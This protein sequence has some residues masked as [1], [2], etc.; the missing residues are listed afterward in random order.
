MYVRDEFAG[1]GGGGV[2]GRL[3]DYDWGCWRE[4]FGGLR[5]GDKGLDVWLGD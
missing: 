5:W 3:Q 4:G 2:S 1:G